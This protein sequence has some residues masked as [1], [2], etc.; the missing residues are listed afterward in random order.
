MSA[1]SRYRVYFVEKTNI[2]EPCMDVMKIAELGEKLGYK[3]EEPK[4]F[5]QEEEI[6]IAEQ[7]KQKEEWEEK[8]RKRDEKLQQMEK[9]LQDWEAKN[10]QQELVIEEQEDEHKREVDILKLIPTSQ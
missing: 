3:G 8:L 5:M 6:K 7:A 9:K 1:F 10:K 4:N 2:H